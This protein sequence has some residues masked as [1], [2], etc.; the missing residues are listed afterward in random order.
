MVGETDFPGDHAGWNKG[1][2]KCENN[3]W[4]NNTA[5]GGKLSRL[6]PLPKKLEVLM[7]KRLTNSGKMPCWIH[8]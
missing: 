2:T 4:K 8:L 1:N 6:L 7:L 3:L 5:E